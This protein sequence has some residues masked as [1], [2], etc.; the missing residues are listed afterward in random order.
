MN[1]VPQEDRATDTKDHRLVSV[2]TAIERAM[3]VHWCIKSDTLQFRIVMQVLCRDGVGW[4]D[5][6]P[7]SLR[8]QWEKWRA[9]LAALEGLRIARCH[10]PREFDEIKNA[11]LHH[12]SDA[13]QNGYG[14]CTYLR[15]VDLKNRVHCSLA[16]GK[17]RVTP[18]KPI[19]IPRLELTAALVSAKISCMSRKEMEY[20]PMK[21]FF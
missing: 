15:L 8:P 1:S 20:A 9:E 5:E 2:D 6:I 3:G 7:D 4:D 10:Q 11:E 12:F 17:S 21:K 14:Q 19:T 13:S 18:L 16:M